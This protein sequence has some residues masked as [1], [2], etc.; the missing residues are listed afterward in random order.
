METVQPSD[1][2]SAFA[3]LAHTHW[4]KPKKKNAK[5]KVKNDV[6]NRNVWGALEADGFAYGALLELESLSLLER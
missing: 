4:L 3:K 6:L 5:T 2:L 1:D